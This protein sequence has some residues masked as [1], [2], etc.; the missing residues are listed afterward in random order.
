MVMAF[1]WHRGHRGCG[2]VRARRDELDAPRTGFLGHPR[3]QLAQHGPWRDNLLAEDVHRDAEAFEQARRPGARERVERLAGAG[4]GVLVDLAT[5]Q[6][7]VQQVRYEQ[8]GFRGVQ[9]RLAA[10]G[11][12]IEL[13]E[14]VQVHELDTG[15]TEDLGL[16]HAAEHLIQHP[17]RA[18]VAVVVWIAEQ[19]VLAVEQR[20]VHAPGVQ[21]DA[22]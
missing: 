12:G 7:E 10:H 8:Q 14:G 9:R 3:Q 17:F 2:V 11:R 6:P 5:C 4:D 21:P 18:A 20:V 19:S 13:D 1:R 22:G 16:R 15:C